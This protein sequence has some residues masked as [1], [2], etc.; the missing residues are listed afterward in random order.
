MLSWI[1]KIFLTCTAIA[2]VGFSYA[3]VAWFAGKTDFAAYSV[4]ASLF[5]ILVCIWILRYAKNNLESFNY[6]VSSVEAADRENM[7]FLLLYILPLFT[8][9]FDALNWVVW[10]P[11][12]IIF[13][14]ITST[15]YSYH[16]NPLLGIMGWHFYKVGTPEGVTYV[17]ITKKELRHANEPLVVVQLTEYIVLDIEE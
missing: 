10:A 4:A 16:F 13:A 9:S 7:A 6:Q 11:I 5:L 1:A 3:W 8:A 14:L 17:L 15:G 12:L 2:P